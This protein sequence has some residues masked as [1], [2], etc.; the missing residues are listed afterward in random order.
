MAAALARTAP[1]TPPGPGGV[2]VACAAATPTTTAPTIR[3]MLSPNRAPVRPLRTFVPPCARSRE[4]RRPRRSSPDQ[5]RV[6]GWASVRLVLG[7][8]PRPIVRPP[9]PGRI[10]GFPDYHHR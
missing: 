3:A 2:G 1:P 6:R 9:G 8:D 10:Q 4:H 5:D 7:N